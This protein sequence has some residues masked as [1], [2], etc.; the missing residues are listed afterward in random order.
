MAN[1]KK[2]KAAAKAAKLPL[3]KI[4]PAIGI[5]EHTMLRKANNETDFRAGEIIKIRKLLNLSLEE[6]EEIFLTEDE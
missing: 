5:S 6:V 4:A 3:R 1:K 2:L